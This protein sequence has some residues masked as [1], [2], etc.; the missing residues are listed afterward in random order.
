MMQI[1]YIILA[2][3]GPT[4]VKRLV[5]RL[6]APWAHFI[7]HI[8]RNTAQEPFKLTLSTRSNITFLEQEKRENGTWGDIGIVRA[9]INALKI[10]YDKKEGDSYFIL[11]S[12]QDYPLQSCPK[13]LNFFIQ[14]KGKDF[15]TSFPLPYSALEQGGLNRIE[16]YKINKSLNRGHFLLLPSMFEKDFYSRET[17]GKLNF[18]RKS[19]R[20]KEI[21]NILKK[22]RFPKYLKPYSGS[23]WWALQDTT[24]DYVLH[25][26]KNKPDYIE[27]HEYSLLPDEMFF[28]SIIRCAPNDFLVEFSK[29]YVNWERP[30]G[31]L[32]VTFE[33]ADFEELKLASKDHLFARK[34]D[35][36]KDTGILELIDDELL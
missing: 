7:I 16:K 34:F 3:K 31:P 22:R 10:A 2:H 19:G 8:D 28:Q 15:I 14:N 17:M 32:P 20:I 24:V 36:E 18:M 27:Y 6:D 4:Q 5:D 9:T 26:L 13:I 11:L 12:G 21:F 23:Q 1:N 35:I 29:T 30:S 33:K 25:F